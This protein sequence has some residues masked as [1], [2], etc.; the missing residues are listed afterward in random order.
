MFILETDALL[1]Q[2][3]TRYSRLR[4]SAASGLTALVGFIAQDPDVTDVRWAAYMLATIKHECGDRW[5]PIEEWG[6]GKNQPYGQPVT[7]TDGDG[8]QYINAYYGRGYVQL[9]WRLN[10]DKMG[11]ALGLGNGLVLHPDHALEPATAYAI[12]SYGMRNGSF[13]GKSLKEY[14][15]D[16]TCDHFNAR[17]I[18]NALDRADLIQGYAVQLESMLR[19]SLASG[20]SSS[21]SGSGDASASAATPS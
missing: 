4:P 7:V 5:Q 15:H 3:T 6:R 21:Q 17:R 9:T 10:Y 20:G 8:T 12:M 19:A 1:A 14:I 13:T 18:I 11:K 2:Y 16:D